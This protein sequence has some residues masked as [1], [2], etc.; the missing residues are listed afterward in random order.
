MPDVIGENE[1]KHMLGLFK[2]LVR[3]ISRVEDIVLLLLT[4]PIA[5]P[6]Y[7]REDG[8]RTKTIGLLLGIP[9]FIVTF[10]VYSYLFLLGVTVLGIPEEYTGSFRLE[11]TN[12]NDYFDTFFF[13][14]FFPIMAFSLYA[15]RTDHVDWNQVRSHFDEAVA[16]VPSKKEIRAVAEEKRQVKEKNR[17]ILVL[18]WKFLFWITGFLLAIL[19]IA[20][21]GAE[22]AT[23]WDEFVF[24]YLFFGVALAAS[25]AFAVDD[26]RQHKKKRAERE[27]PKENDANTSSEK[28]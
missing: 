5:M 24:L 10:Y 21:Y 3:K 23:S 22:G 20:N 28:K 9:G 14:L 25:L 17:R 16:H 27:K 15:V 26:R 18:F 1:K 7:L 12:P 13:S 11:S 6:F 2:R 8:S 4:L 19:L